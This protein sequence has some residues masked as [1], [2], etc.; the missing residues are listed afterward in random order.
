MFLKLGTRAILRIVHIMQ[1]NI[2][3]DIHGVQLASL[4]YNFT[5]YIFETLQVDSR[6]ATIITYSGYCRFTNLFEASFSLKM[7]MEIMSRL[8]HN[9]CKNP[10]ELGTFSKF[11]WFFMF[12]LSYCRSA[13]FSNDVEVHMMFEDDNKA[14]PALLV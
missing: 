7:C 10:F 9:S 1:R 2:S 14:D 3:C 8:N 6:C 5:A 13:C 12:V 11:L 4:E